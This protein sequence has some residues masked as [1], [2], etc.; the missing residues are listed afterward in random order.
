MLGDGLGVVWGD[1]LLWVST[2]A[3]L[4]VMV[5]ALRG[6][7]RLKA[8]LRGRRGHAL[9]SV[10]A[11]VIA[12][13][14]CGQVLSVVNAT[15]IVVGRQATIDVR[16]VLFLLTEVVQTTAVLYGFRRIIALSSECEPGAEGD[17][18]GIITEQ[19]RSDQQ[20]GSE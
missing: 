15:L 16:V 12:A 5:Y 14:T 1:M 7:L 18:M 10:M 11:V 13:I 6:V 9:T 8:H 2:I 3:L 19:L 4:G 20:G 17:T